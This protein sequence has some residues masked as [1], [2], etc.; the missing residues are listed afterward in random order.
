M[1]LGEG[2]EE[3]CDSIEII[4]TDGVH[5]ISALLEGMLLFIRSP[6]SDLNRILGFVYIFESWTH[7]YHSGLSQHIEPLLNRTNI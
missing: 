3:K 6:D 2:S 5:E 7:V 1:N 4:A